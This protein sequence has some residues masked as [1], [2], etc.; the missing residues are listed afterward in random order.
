MLWRATHL[1]PAL[2]AP[3]S[4][5]RRVP[6]PRSQDD[7]NPVPGTPIPVSSYQTAPSLPA[8]PAQASSVGP[9][10]KGS[11]VLPRCTLLEPRGAQ[12]MTVYGEYGGLLTV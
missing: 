2:S 12:G 8:G 10:L 3:L 9:S 6:G 7:L 5:G 4:M 1:G 11:T